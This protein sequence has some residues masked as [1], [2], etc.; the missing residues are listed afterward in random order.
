MEKC[1]TEGKARPPEHV[2]L[3][4]NQNPYPLVSNTES[5]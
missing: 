3:S 1:R 5:R 2:K 4:L